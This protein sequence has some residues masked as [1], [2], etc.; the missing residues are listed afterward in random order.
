MRRV[1]HGGIDRE[2]FIDF[3][4]SI[5]PIKPPFFDDLFTDELIKYVQKY[6]YVEWLEE[7]FNQKY[8]ED[9]V[10]L[11]GATEAF[12]IIGST[13]MENAQVIIPTPN[14]GEYAPVARLKAHKVHFVNILDI[15]RKTLDYSKL[16]NYIDDLRKKLKNNKKMLIIFSNPNNP[17]GYY[18]KNIVSHINSI[19][20]L[21]ERIIIVIDEAFLDFIPAEERTDLSNLENV[22]LIRTFTKF[23]GIPGI[24]VG[25]VKS[26]RYKRLFKN[27]RAP[28]GIGAAG[29]LFLKLLL[30]E[31]QVKLAK[32]E[33]DTIKYL[34]QER[35]KFQRYIY[36]PS[37]VN[38]F[39]VKVGQTNRILHEL[40]C[41]K[42]HVRTLYD[43]GMDQFIRI[44]LKERQLNQKILDF[45]NQKSSEFG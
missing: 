45:L 19:Q 31:E 21:D 2:N 8:G 14:Y 30:D 23:Y 41:Q 32:F 10:I 15:N 12:Q 6:T 37:S 22:I 39:T 20:T 28:W 34:Q 25:Y 26:K 33:K 42:L 38:Y 44:G 11:A 17:T 40:H 9:T 7:K 4:I 18:E 5:N 36:F 43:F 35:E 1:F 16:T 13:L 27:Y 3:S 29:Y 24:R